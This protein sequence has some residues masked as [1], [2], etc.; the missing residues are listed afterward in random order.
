MWNVATLLGIFARGKVR[1]SNH[2]KKHLWATKFFLYHFSG[3]FYSIKPFFPSLQLQMWTHTHTHT[4][5]RTHTRTHCT[6]G[7]CSLVYWKKSRSLQTPSQPTSFPTTPVSSATPFSRTRTPEIGTNLNPTSRSV[8]T[9]TI[10][11]Y[12]M[13]RI[14]KSILRIPRQRDFSQRLENVTRVSSTALHMNV[15][16][17]HCGIILST[18]ELR[19]DTNMVI[20]VM[21]LITRGSLSYQS[22]IRNSSPLQTHKFLSNRRY[23]HILKWSHTHTHTQA[24]LLFH[25]PTIKQSGP[26]IFFSV[27]R[28]KAV[29]PTL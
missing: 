2:A 9:T 20:N 26:G 18:T 13:C 23:T 6:V 25:G 12:S 15:H 7:Y 24:C 28:L 27:H 17:S 22:S 3:I 8:Q 14:L 4:H 10:E 21:G 16:T 19:V 11:F 1:L 29:P 5:T